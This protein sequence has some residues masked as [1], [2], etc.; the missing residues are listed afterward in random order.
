M[1]KS[2]RKKLTI[3][4]IIISLFSVLL[5]AIIS[6]FVLEV[7]FREYVKKNIV[8]KSE[9]IVSSIEKNYF[10]GSWNVFAIENIGVKALENGM[11]IKVVDN[12]GNVIW[13][14][15]QYNSG[16]CQNMITHY[17]SNMMRR[18]PNF[19][20]E[21]KEDVH[22]AEYN[23]KKIAEVHIGYYGPYYFTDNDIL[24][25]NTLNGAIIVVSI[26]TI[27]ISILLG[28]LISNRISS[29][30]VKVSKSANKISEGEYE[31]I[32]IVSDIGE[33]DELI[34]SIN[35]LSEKLKNQEYLRKR[36]TQ[37]V[38]HELRTPLSTLKSHIEAMIDGI[39]EPSKDRLK[40]CLEEAERLNG[41]VGDIYKLTKYENEEKLNLT[42]FNLGELL[43]N[44]IMNFE[45]SMID[46]GLLVIT[47]IKD[48]YIYADRDKI[49]QAIINLISNAVKFSKKGGKIIISTVQSE[50]NI[51]VFIKDEGI[52][53]S[54]KDLPYIFERFYRADESRNRD[55]G[56]AGIGLSITK[57]IIDLHKGDIT[58]KSK[59][60][61]GSEFII[62]IPIM[63]E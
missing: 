2:L 32:E 1:T 31:K 12:D 11:I 6:N 25:L 49:A 35:N 28:R 8:N 48:V 14:A 24:F 13:D 5:I 56:G 15:K 61:E 29:P 16:Q 44:I 58:V 26:L 23:S 37:D 3:S 34:N 33:I 52:G 45:K 50:K 53:I 57:S 36:L 55:T 17:S 4:Y 21:F 40:S 42:R 43:Q 10:N 59:Q 30:I 46:K 63:H 20:G 51:K 39:W 9:E 62:T 27:A 22:R 7:Q 54:Q 19:K 41:L 47:D 60:N 38:A 18:Y